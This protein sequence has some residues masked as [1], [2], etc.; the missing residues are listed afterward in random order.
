MNDRRLIYIPALI[1]GILLV[2]TFG[3]HLVQ[4]QYSLFD[5]FYMTIIT[6]TTVG[7]AEIWPL[8]TAGRIFNIFMLISGWIII[9]MVARLIGQ[10]ILEGAIPRIIGGQ[11]M[12]RQLEQIS[13]HYI[14]CGYG[15]VGQV[16]CDEFLHHK[17]PFT[18]IERDPG[19]IEEL[20]SKGLLHINGDCTQ[21][22]VLI[23]AGIT[24][25]R[26]LINAITDSA[27]SVYTTLS[28]RL[29][30]PKLFIMARADSPS[31]E[32]ML[33]RAGADRVIS[34][35]VAAGTRMA[36]AAIRPNVVDFV[37]LAVS[38]DTQG[39]RVEEIHVP[40]NSILIG[41]TFKEVDI[42]AKYGLNIIG[43]K[44]YDGTL[45]YNPP[46]DYSIQADD[47]LIMVGSI[48]QFNKSDELFQ[49]SSHQI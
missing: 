43:V 40:E 5:S 22:E 6:I 44:K 27:E 37:S 38:D 3:Y 11:V 45:N 16:V 29:H 20:K 2:G 14:V 19:L 36:M 18:V 28:A 33:K 30:N 4:P 23:R 48:D 39:M 1:I 9:V 25:A 13:D 12:N 47:T 26:G 7:Y 21:D 41:K 42:R 10:M 15:R 32:Q 17:M 24:R 35:H 8:T 46:A 49:R 34:P 31:S